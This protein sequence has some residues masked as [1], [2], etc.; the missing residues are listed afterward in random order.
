MSTFYNK[1]KWKKLTGT[2][3]IPEVVGLCM[4]LN[5]ADETGTPTGPMYKLF[6]K[7]W[8]SVK[9]SVRGWFVSQPGMFK[10]GKIHDVAVQSD[11]WI[12][13]LLCLDKEGKLN[14]KGLE[15]CLKELVKS[16][17]YENA[18]IHVSELLLNEIPELEEALN[19]HLVKQGVSVYSYSGDL[20]K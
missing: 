2:V 20:S 13:T 9:A 5:V 16:A 15:T 10:L 8:K 7:K 11:V 6:D 17:K 19:E 18:T 4:V 1:A 12:M 3:L 14:S